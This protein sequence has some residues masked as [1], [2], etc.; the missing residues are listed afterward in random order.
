[1][2]ALKILTMANLSNQLSWLY[3]IIFLYSTT[4]TAPQF[5]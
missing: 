4:H 1:M 3:Q 2:S 5:L